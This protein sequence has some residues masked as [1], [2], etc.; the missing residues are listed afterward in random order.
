MD[1]AELD[2]YLGLGWY[3]IGQS[4]MTTDFISNDDKFAPVFWLRIDLRRY[5]PTRSA[6]RIIDRNKNFDIFIKP[7]E[8][9]SE[10]E[11]LFQSYRNSVDFALPRTVHDYLLDGGNENAYDSRLITVRDEGELLAAGYFD[12][13]QKSTTGI[14]HFANPKYSR[15]S[16]GKFLFLVEIEYARQKGFDFYYPG[17]LSTEF[18]KFDY[19]LFA[20]RSSTEVFLRQTMR[21][22]DYIETAPKL[23]RWGKKITAA[24]NKVYR[25]VPGAE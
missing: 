24:A 20:D 3:R 4:F 9:T 2:H 25:L 8:I 14:L 6:R 18:A 19:K 12:V 16:L 17:Y 11:A 7:F 21:W 23:A 15:L 1:G 22:H 10:I 5:K 13:G